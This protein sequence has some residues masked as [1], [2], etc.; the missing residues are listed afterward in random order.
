V[1]NWNVQDGVACSDVMTVSVLLKIAPVGRNLE[2]EGHTGNIATSKA[3]FIFSRKGRR[4]KVMFI[5]I[6]IAN[7][8]ARKSGYFAF[9][10]TYVS[11]VTL[12]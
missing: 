8:N 6:L 4:L 5:I 10:S 1:G 7:V 11:T 12:F 2:M 9:K 3:Y